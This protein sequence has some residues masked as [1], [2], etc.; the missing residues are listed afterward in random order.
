MKLLLDTCTFLWVVTAS[1][2]LSL[3]V[4]A[5]VAAPENEVYL[6]AVSAWEIVVKHQLGRLPLPA[7]PLEFVT[8]QRKLHEIESLALQENAIAQLS[9]LPDYHNDPFD[10][11]LICQAITHG[12][13]LLTPDKSISQYPVLTIW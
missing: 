11:M 9:R 4:R 10:R 7:P 13:S 12:M 6:S 1:S 5:L 8:E 2:D 3:K